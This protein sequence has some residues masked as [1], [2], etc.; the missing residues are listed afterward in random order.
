MGKIRI[1]IV[2]YGN[3]GRGVEQSIK[4]NDDMELKAVF[5]RRDPASVKIQTEGAEVKHFDDMEAMK[6]DIDV[7]IL[8]G[9][10]ATDLPVIGPKVAASFNTIDSFDTHAKIPEYFANVDKAAKEGKNVS[11][12]SVGWDPGMFSLNRLYAESILVQGSTYTFW[13]KGVSQGHSDAIR[14]IEGVKNGIQYTVPIEAAVDQ[15]RSGSEPELTTR[16]KHLRECYVVAEEGADKAAIEEAIKT[17]PNYFDE[18]D[19]TVTF[20]T[21]EE[22]KANHSKMP[23]GGFVIRTG[24]TGCEGNKHVIEYSLKLDSNPEFT[25][26]VLVAYARAAHRLSQKGE[27]GARSVFDIAP[28][29]LSQ[30]TPEELR[31]HML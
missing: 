10:S 7:M 5:T 6:D 25:G 3:I 28:A 4:R 27:S 11:I 22:L 19:T 21:E 23:H 2:G 8:C 13:G 17:M 1:G 12:I 30:M 16:Q 20:I 9:G 14:R 26:S 29:M 31:A 15:V 24:E 18:Y